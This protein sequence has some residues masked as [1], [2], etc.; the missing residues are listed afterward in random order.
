MSFLRKYFGEKAFYIKTATIAIPLALQMLLQSCMSIIDMMMVSSIGMVTAVGNTSQIIMLHDG[1]SWGVSSGIAMFSAQFFGA[2]QN[3]NLQKTFALGLILG[4]ANA[5]IWTLVSMFFGRDLLYFYLK[6]LEVLHYSML[7]LR[8][9]MFYLIPY[10]VNQSFMTMFRSTQQ[11]KITLY[12]SVIG[13]LLNVGLNYLFIFVLAY[14]VEGAAMG[15]VLAQLIV[16]VIN[17]TYAIKTKQPFIQDFASAFKI[18]LSFVSPIVKKMT[19]LIVNEMLFGVGMTLFV[20]AYG[21]LGTLSMDAYY[22]SNQIFNLFLFGVHGYGLAVSV[23][24][25]A[26]L[27]EGR[28]ELAKEESNYQLGLG[29]ILGIVMVFIMSVFAKPLVY[30]FGYSK[31]FVFD[32]AVGLLYVFAIKL[33]LRMFN[34]MMFS[35][36]RAGGDTKIL[37]FLD[38]GLVYGVG[39]TLAF[40]SVE[41]LKIENIVLVVLICQIEQVVRLILTM[42][43]YR[44]AKWAKDLTKLVNS[45][46]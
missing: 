4:V 37:N 16:L 19:P 26:R 2:K 39:L 21:S 46:N 23:L 9:M 7:Y 24:I 45:S 42:I 34:F 27:G 5:T 28:I 38:S 44:Q 12:V 40:F 6:D 30:M 25:G 36:L 32:M 3:K 43:R 1:I 10:A 18:D 14:G 41:V 13:A 35:T 20:K 33:F 8:I 31:G 29:F 15:S 11:A 17:V 22:V